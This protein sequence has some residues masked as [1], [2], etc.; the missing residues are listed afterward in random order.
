M[1]LRSVS[2]EKF[3]EVL[4]AME[5]NF[6]PEER[7]D[8][9]DARAV[10]EKENYR[11]FVFSEG[12]TALGFVTVW[13]LSTFAF[14][15]H[16]VTYEAHRNRGYGAAVLTLLKQRYGR[17]VL[18]AEPPATPMAE[19]RL[20]FYERNGFFASGVPYLQPSYR[21]GGESVPLV[22]LSCPALPEDAVAAV[23]GEIYHTVYGVTPSQQETQS[24]R[25]PQ[26]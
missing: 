10:L 12:E 19:R 6:P 26:Q 16:F 8:A 20:G 14:V 25:R 4:A 18:E 23:I 13:E 9:A 17:L 7:R 1:E 2:A 22:L 3:E 15:E 21:V 5:R 11:V 24:Q